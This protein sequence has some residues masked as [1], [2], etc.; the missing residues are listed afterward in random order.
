MGVLL[1]QG[2]G[3]DPGPTGEMFIFWVHVCGKN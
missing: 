2:V 1:K 3:T